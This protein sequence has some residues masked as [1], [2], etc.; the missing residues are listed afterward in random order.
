MLLRINCVRHD[1]QSY[2]TVIFC[3]KDFNL[4]RVEFDFFCSLLFH[5]FPFVLS[6]DLLFL[7]SRVQDTG[8]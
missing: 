2:E 5:C 4:L 6:L 8:P 1:E 3:M 7:I